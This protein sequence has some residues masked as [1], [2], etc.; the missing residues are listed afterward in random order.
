MGHDI[1]DADRPLVALVTGAAGGI[2]SAVCHDLSRRGY[3][4]VAC[5]RAGD[6]LS[7]L[8]TSIQGK[9]GR[10]L[11]RQFDLA[12]AASCGDAIRW[13]DET[14][15]RLDVLVNNAGAWFYEHF[16]DST[17]EHWRY[18]LEV[19]VVAAA[20]LSRLAVPLLRRSQRPRIVNIGSKNGWIGQ[21]RLSSYNV[22]KAAIEALTR[23]LAVELA[24]TG[25]LVNC[26]APG[27]ID[28]DSTSYL[29]DHAAREATRQR[30][31]LDR[32]GRPGEVARAVAYFCGEDCSFATGATLLV[33]GGQLS[34][35]PE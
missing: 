8:A 26:V 12:D 31:P 3:L 32:V 22:S 13:L 2:G 21:S 27:V 5:G 19:N 10:C 25:I 23:S 4:I 7:A 30:I 20:R 6:E 35:D 15:G 24:A 28:T 11:T 16:L 9:G 29:E 17:D 18:V 1:G 14:L 33:D 34:G